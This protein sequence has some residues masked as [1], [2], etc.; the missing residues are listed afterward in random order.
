MNDAN[1]CRRCHWQL[2]NTRIWCLKHYDNPAYAI[3]QMKKGM[4]GECKDYKKYN[5]KNEG[6]KMKK[7]FS[8]WIYGCGR[9]LLYN[10][11]CDVDRKHMKQYKLD[12]K[13]GLTEE[14]SVNNYF[15]KEH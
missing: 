1:D 6:E 4:I 8:D 14:E 15:N 3:E 7:T 10:H 9:I 11:G 2:Q 13:L 5:P 12:F